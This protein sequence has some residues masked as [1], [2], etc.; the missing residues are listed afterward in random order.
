LRR[1]F[2]P[3]SHP[4]APQVWSSERLSSALSKGFESDTPFDAATEWG[5]DHV[6]HKIEDSDRWQNIPICEPSLLIY[7]N[8]KQDGTTTDTD[9]DSTANIT[10]A[11]STA[12]IKQHRLVSCLWA[13]AGY[14]TRGER[15][16][17]NDGQRCLLVTALSN[18]NRED[19]KKLGMPFNKKN[20]FPDP[21]SRFGNGNDE[22][23]VLHTKAVAH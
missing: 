21:T 3:G 17:I 14:S 6:L 15:F 7:G 2:G 5:T 1:F 9:A 11:D 22:A 16:A 10:A 4:D 19:Y 12:Q 20:V 18:L 23:L 8:N 13:S